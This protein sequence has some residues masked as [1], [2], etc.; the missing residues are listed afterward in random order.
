[1]KIKNLQITGIG[2]IQYLN[3]E[4][5][6]SMNYICGPNGI[7]KTTVL[8]CISHLFTATRTSILKRN[9]SMESGSVSANVITPDGQKP[10]TI[11][12][13]DFDPSSKAQINGLYKY[14]ELILSLKTHRTFNYQPLN[15]IS[16]DPDKNNTHTEAIKGVQ[17]NDV[18]NWF[19]NRFLYSAHEDALDKEQISNFKL[20][21]KCFSLLDE[22]FSFKTVKADTNEI[23]LS[24]PDGDIYYEYL[25]SGFKYCLS[26]LFGIIKEIE[27]RFKEKKVKAAD[28]NGI[29]VIDEIELHLHPLWQSKIA[30]VL[31][32][33]FPNVQ[34]ITTTHSPHV[35]Q[36]AE[37]EQI[38]AIEYTEK[39]KRIRPL[40]NTKYG[41]KGWTIEEVLRDVMGMKDIRTNVFE[42]ILKSF[43][44]AIDDEN[45]HNA[46][47]IFNEIDELLHPD[48]H[49]RKLLRFQL[50][51]IKE[52]PDDKIE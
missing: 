30:E 39:G 19:A 3:I 16:K 32:N 49:M 8:E 41:F 18:K 6:S 9:A 42:G 12:L 23:I 31:I 1:M 24:T 51:S 20:A 52:E 22:N 7:G 14:A 2:G 38:L 10:I 46:N 50:A 29:V 21:K 13:T 34:F 4:L 45:Y 28:F 37:P 15:A 33:V 36:A 44:E 35:I 5:N 40:P 47:E 43:N 17:Y 26:I 48:N 25:S 27:F 11:E